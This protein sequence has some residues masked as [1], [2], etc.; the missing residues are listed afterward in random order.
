MRFSP[1]AEA[2]R[3][4]ERLGG[5]GVRE[6]VRES[7]RDDDVRASIPAAALGWRLPFF[8]SAL[9][10]RVPG[11]PG[12]PGPASSRAARPPRPLLVLRRRSG[13]GSLGAASGLAL[14]R[15]CIPAGGSISKQVRI[16][17][18]L[19]ITSRGEESRSSSLLGSSPLGTMSPVSACSW[20]GCGS[21]RATKLLRVET[22]CW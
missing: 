13:D 12:V 5:E 19:V 7:D 14:V 4:T 8:I 3:L 10:S 21:F 2:A 20:A 6:G 16:T 18:G 17:T 15:C 9:E 22:A 11:V 1:A